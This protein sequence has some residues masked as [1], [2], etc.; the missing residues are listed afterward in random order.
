MKRVLFFI[1]CG[2]LALA[3][4]VVAWTSQE[5]AA[6]TEATFAPWAREWSGP[7]TLSNRLVGDGALLTE[8]APLWNSAIGC[9]VVRV[10][11]P[12]DP[13][14]VTVSWAV[15]R[16]EKGGHYYPE[17]GA[18]VLSQDGAGRDLWARRLMHEIGHVLGLDHDS[19][20]L[21]AA[22]VNHTTPLR[23]SLADVRAVRARHCQR[24]DP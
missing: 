20:G 2:L 7:V 1:G 18:V 3:I 9:E 16:L 11:G 13:A 21:M 17:I 6:R 10:T 19:D 22:A 5:R 8:V 4:A 24:K 23:P 15:A 14:D 12:D